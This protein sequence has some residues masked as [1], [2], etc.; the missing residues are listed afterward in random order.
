MNHLRS[1]ISSHKSKST[2]KDKMIEKFKNLLKNSENSTFLSKVNT[3]IG[4]TLNDSLDKN[5]L[6]LSMSIPRWV[7]DKVVNNCLNCVKKFSFFKRKHHCRMCGNIFCSECCSN[8]TNFFP[9][10]I[11][12]VRTCENC[13]KMQKESVNTQQTN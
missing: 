9:Y 6:A 7:P 2:I 10:Y 1:E 3:E 12:L 4:T 5:R 8:Y 11:G 13:Y